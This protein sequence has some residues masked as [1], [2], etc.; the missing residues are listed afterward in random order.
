MIAV[1]F[2]INHYLSI[3]GEEVLG[4]QSSNAKW[5]RPK[6]PDINPNEDSIIFQ[7]L[8]I[9]YIIGQ[10]MPGMPGCTQGQ[11]PIVRMF[12]VTMD[13]HSVLCNV[14]GFL[15]YFYIPAPPNFQQSDCSLFRVIFFSF[16]TKYI[17]TI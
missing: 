1:I 5:C 12:G 11:V 16:N 3:T 4:S 2:M 7:Q 8:D 9:D 6:P 15:P 14:H 13:G 10:S 17:N